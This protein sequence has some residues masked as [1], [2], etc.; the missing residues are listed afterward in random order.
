M[1]ATS[2]PLVAF[3]VLNL[4]DSDISQMEVFYRVRHEFSEELRTKLFKN[5]LE[6]FRNYTQFNPTRYAVVTWILEQDYGSSADNLAFVSN[7]NKFHY[8]YKEDNIIIKQFYIHDVK[9]TD[10]I[11]LFNL[12]SKE[13][14]FQVFYATDGATSLVVYLYADDQLEFASTSSSMGIEVCSNTWTHPS[15]G[16]PNIADDLVTG[17]NVG[18]PGMWMFLI[19]DS[20]IILPGKQN[21]Q[22]QIKIK[23]KKISCVKIHIIKYCIDTIKI[24]V[25]VFT[26]C[27]STGD[28]QSIKLYHYLL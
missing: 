4:S 9:S 28:R 8:N 24:L 21:M 23:I 17:S 3:T 27:N 26:C 11:M 20:T 5:F 14:T 2:P 15:S 19:K 13:D 16:T 12:L 10:I 18:T 25:L 22:N 6:A 7:T 1:N